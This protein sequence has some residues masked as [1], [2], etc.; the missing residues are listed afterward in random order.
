VNLIIDKD[1]TIEPIRIL[2]RLL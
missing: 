1:Y 2:V